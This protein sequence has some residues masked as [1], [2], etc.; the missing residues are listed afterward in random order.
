VIVEFDAVPVDLFALD[1]SDEASLGFRAG[2]ALHDL[3]D[4]VFE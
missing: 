2:Y 3:R 1:G 4:G